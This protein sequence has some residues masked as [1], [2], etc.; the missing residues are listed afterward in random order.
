[1]RRAIGFTKTARAVRR[2]EPNTGREFKPS[3]DPYFAEKFAERVPA[4][5]NEW[6]RRQSGVPLLPIT[7]AEF[8]WQLYNFGE[9][10]A[11]FTDQRSQGYIW[12][13]DKL[14]CDRAEL[15][16]F[17]SGHPD[18]VWFLPQPV[19]GL[20]HYNPRQDRISRRSEE[21]ITSF[22]FA[23]LESDCQPV[24]QWLR[25]LVQLPLPIV[26]ITTSGR[27]SVHALVRV[28][29]ASKRAWDLIVREGLLPRLV[30]LGA[31]PQAL[32][33]VRLSRL[34]GCY[35]SER[36]QELHYFDPLATA[37]PI[38][39]GRIN[40]EGRSAKLVRGGCS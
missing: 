35:R 10:I 34:P 17:V 24:E 3:F 7:P 25:I 13:K 23:V 29:A 33:T 9:R 28:D 21:S 20:K 26:S 8:L 2:H 22:R 15:D 36:Q 18:G 32:T 38:W 5:T 31:D 19:D 6:L 14:R 39:K 16:R 11:I 4:I 1:L 27:K 37:K 40:D 12:R 30:K